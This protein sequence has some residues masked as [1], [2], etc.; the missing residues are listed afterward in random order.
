MTGAGVACLLSAGFA[1]VAA[2]FGDEH[3]A[4]AVGWVVGAQSLAWI[5]G[6]P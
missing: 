3:A 4:W 1:G 6:N 5:G 2:Y